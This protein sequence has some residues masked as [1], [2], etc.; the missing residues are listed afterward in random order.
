MNLLITGALGHIGS[1]IF[2]D[3]TKIK[4][5]KK[6]YLID[7]IT[8]QR[9]SVIFKINHKKIKFLYGDLTDP[10]IC[11]KIPKTD[12]VIHLASITDS[13]NSFNIKN[14]IY[15]NNI[16]AF[17]N[18]LQYCAK[19]KAKLIHISS[20]SVYGQKNK[21]ANEKEVDLNPSSPYAKIKLQEEKILKKQKKVKY[22]TLR[23]GTISGFS[24]GMR[25]HTA[26]NKFCFNSV[27]GLPIPIWGG[28]TK[29][30]RPYLS[31]KD[32]LKTIKFII[33][34][35]YFPSQIFNVL[36]ENKTVEQILN[37]IKKHKIKIKKINIVSKISNQLSFITSKNKIEKLGIKLNTKIATDI[38]NTIKN[39]KTY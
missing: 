29:L 11:S 16:G 25:F 17:K 33:N 19:N 2:N 5:I 13:E 18:I 35:K 30:Y 15:R 21:I 10:K 27:M 38:N 4:K 36:S 24:I 3:L 28:T 6:I 8:N 32:A 14:Q 1:Y 26:V 12:I 23:F 39:L 20:T 37:I 34:K 31:L 22:I 9:F 7:N